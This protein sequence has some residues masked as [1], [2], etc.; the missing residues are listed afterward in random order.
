MTQHLRLSHASMHAAVVATCDNLS[1]HSCAAFVCAL[2][3][4]Q[5]AG[6]AHDQVGCCAVDLLFCPISDCAPVSM[7]CPCAWMCMMHSK[8]A[9]PLHKAICRE[10]FPSTLSAPR[11]YSICTNTHLLS[12]GL[13]CCSLHCLL[14]CLHTQGIRPSEY[15]ED[16]AG[17]LETWA[18]ARWPAAGQRAFQ[19]SYQVCCVCVVCGKRGC[20]LWYWFVVLLVVLVGV[21][22]AH[23]CRQAVHVAAPR[24]LS[25]WF[26]AHSRRAHVVLLQHC[27]S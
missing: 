11:V 22:L 20:I 3:H 19:W 27:V 24:A 2:Q 6:E 16:P 5:V 23:V 15:P 25:W 9:R 18:R 1:N 21:L 26:V 17:A 4:L 8:L 10:E 13:G 12:C 14:S 7:L